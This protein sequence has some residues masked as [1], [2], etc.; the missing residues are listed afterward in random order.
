MRPRKHDRNPR[1]DR[2]APQQT[3]LISN[4]YIASLEALSGRIKRRRRMPRAAPRGGPGAYAARPLKSLL[5][6]LFLVALAPAESFAKPPDFADDPNAWNGLGRLTAIASA[7]QLEVVA[8]EQLSLDGLSSRDGL[9]I[10]G[11]T[12]TLPRTGLSNFLRGGGRVAVADDFGPSERFLRAFGIRR[13]PLPSPADNSLSAPRLRGNPALRLATPAVQHTLSQSVPVVVTNHPSG[14]RHAT[15]EPVLALGKEGPALVLTGAVGAG[16]LV[17]IGDPSVL[18][19][20]MLA[21]PGNAR[22]A[23]NLLRYLTFGGGRLW[24]VS[25]GSRLESAA[26]SRGPLPPLASVRKGLSRLSEA[27]LPPPVL[28]LAGWVLA[29]SMLMAALSALPRP[30][31]YGSAMPLSAASPLAGVAGRIWFFRHRATNFLAPALTFKLELERRLTDALRLPVAVQDAELSAGLRRAGLSETEVATAL[32]TL[33]AL[34]D[35]STADEPPPVSARRFASLVDDG[36][37]I[38]T[39]LEERSTR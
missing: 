7:L 27:A 37:A 33:H 9:L 19:N 24:V 35:L 23:E 20:N 2:A 28:R 21:F 29:I 32:D 34:R 4:S 25:G 14:L 26:D 38:L 3:I 36:A 8:P 6:G 1:R 22:F 17:A 18:I 39:R 31:A 12:R 16:R 15:L 30:T 13:G 10:V 5:C 11:P